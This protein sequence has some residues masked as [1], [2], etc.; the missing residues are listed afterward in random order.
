VALTARR[1]RRVLLWSVDAADRLI[2]GT[3]AGLSRAYDRL[4]PPRPPLDHPELD[5]AEDV[6]DRAYHARDL[7]GVE[8]S[9]THLNLACRRLFAVWHPMATTGQRPMAA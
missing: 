8:A 9:C 7:A 4:P 3:Y 1:P 6:I 2:A 5:R